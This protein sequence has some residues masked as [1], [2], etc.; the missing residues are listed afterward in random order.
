[1]G[2]KKTVMT[3]VIEVDRG[4]EYRRLT[5]AL[6]GST[7]GGQTF[8]SKKAYDRR[9]GKK[10]DNDKQGGI[11]MQREYKNGATKTPF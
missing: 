2:K 3:I 4:K 11:T 7:R 9:E 8:K 10:I 6:I 1:M 5:R